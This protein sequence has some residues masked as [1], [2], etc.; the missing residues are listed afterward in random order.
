M[1]KAAIE[2]LVLHLITL[3]L[4]VGC[5]FFAESRADGSQLVFAVAAG[6]LLMVVIGTAMDCG[7]Q[8]KADFSRE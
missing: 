4:A 3:S 8:L 6:A 7:R 5:L 2:L 1:S